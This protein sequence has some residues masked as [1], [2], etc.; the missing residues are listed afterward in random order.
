ML[1]GGGVIGLAL[2]GFWLW[3][4]FDVI[5]T[6]G[7]VV[8]N[9]PKF[10][11]LMLVIFLSEIGAIAWLLLGRP[12]HAGFRPGDTTPRGGRRVT[13]PEDGPLWAVQE[14]QRAKYE[15][16]DEELDRRIEA[17]R[18]QEWDDELRRR[19]AELRERDEKSSGS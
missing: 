8:R 2:L 4:I 19:E 11:W 3:A 16:M 5:S 6:D 1:Y 7:S 14:S 18:L 9:L 15:E 13:G 10:M 17:K 12:E